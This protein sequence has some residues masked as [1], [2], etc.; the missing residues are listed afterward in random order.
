M[1]SARKALPKERGI[2]VRETRDGTRYEYIYTDSTGKTRWVTCSTLKE[3]RQG[4]AAKVAAL[5]RGEQ[6]G[7]EPA[8]SF[9][10]PFSYRYR[11]ADYMKACRP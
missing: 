5:A 11:L 6:G 10:T 3:A 8:C 4:R 2:Y 9:E 1:A 7:A